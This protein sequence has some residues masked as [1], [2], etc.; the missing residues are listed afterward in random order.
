MSVLLVTSSVIT[1]TLIPAREFQEG[2]QA[3]GRA[4]SYLAHHFFGDYFGSIYDLSTI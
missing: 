3:N 1:T 4:L 2:G